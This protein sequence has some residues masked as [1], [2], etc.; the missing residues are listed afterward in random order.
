MIQKT[1]CKRLKTCLSQLQQK[2]ASDRQHQMGTL[3][4]QGLRDIGVVGG[5]SVD[6]AVRQRNLREGQRLN[7]QS[8]ERFQRQQASGRNVRDRLRQWWRGGL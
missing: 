4:S 2:L 8:R 6:E 1:A 5:Q 7:N 3:R